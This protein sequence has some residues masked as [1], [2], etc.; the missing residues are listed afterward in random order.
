MKQQQFIKNIGPAFLLALGTF[1]FTITA[2]AASGSAGD[3]SVTTPSADDMVARIVSQL[4]TLTRMVTAIAYVMGM[5]FIMASIMKFK[6]YG[7][8]RT[9]MSM[10]HHLTQPIVYLVVGTFLLYLPSAINTTLSTFWADP[11]PYGYLEASSEWQ[12]SINNCI[13][14]VQFFGLIAF[15]RGLV[16]LSHLGGHHGGQGGIGKGITHIIGGIFCINIYQFVN[17]VLATLGVEIT[18]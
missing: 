1:L 3:V 14:V 2:H 6:Q 15:I 17:L 18:L 4:P 8:A 12:A 9:M 5:G 11:N 13:L 7:E 16:I 10:Q